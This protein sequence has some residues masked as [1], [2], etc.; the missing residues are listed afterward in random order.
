MRDRADA[1]RNEIMLTLSSSAAATASPSIRRKAASRFCVE[2]AS[3]SLNAQIV[4]TFFGVSMSPAK[5]PSTTPIRLPS[6]TKAATVWP[7]TTTRV[8]SSLM[9]NVGVRASSAA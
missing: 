4:A 9:V 5:A 2:L 8:W 1:I 6:A 7:S 3:S